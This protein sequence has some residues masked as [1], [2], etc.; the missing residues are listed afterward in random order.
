MD[1]QSDPKQEQEYL[2]NT[3]ALVERSLASIIT[4]RDAKVEM[5]KDLLS[6]YSSANPEYYNDIPIT[7]SL[8]QLY[9]KRIRGYMSAQSKPYFG[10][11]LFD[12]QGESCNFYIGKIGIMDLDDMNNADNMAGAASVSSE[13][14]ADTKALA[15]IDW[16]APV[17][18][19]YYS[20]SFGK[21]GYEAPGGYIEADIHL[22]TAFEIEGGKIT[23]IYDSD[24]MANDELLLKY[25]SSNKDTVLT[26]IVAT[27]QQEQNDIIRLSPEKTVIVQGVAGSGKTTVA[28]HR[29]SYLLY[30]YDPF[31]NADNVY[32]IASGKL[33]LNYMTSMLPDL[34]VPEIRQGTLFDFLSDYIREYDPKF[35]CVPIAD[36]TMPN[37][38]TVRNDIENINRYFLAYE[39]S[40][41]EKEGDLTLFGVEIVSKEFL[42]Q[43]IRINRGHGLLDRAQLLDKLVAE[44]LTKQKPAIIAYILSH[45]D[46]PA[47]V[48]LC[49]SVLQLQGAAILEEEVNKRFSR[50]VSKYKNQYFSKLKRLN[51]LKLYETLRPEGNAAPKTKAVPGAKAK[52]G[53]AMPFSIPQL[54][55]LALV[56]S[57]L[58]LNDSANEIRHIVID[59]AQ[60]FGLFTYCCLEQIFQKA[61]FTLVGDVM[62]VI[63]QSGLQSWDGVLDY[64]FHGDADFRTLT[65]S[66]RNTIEISAFA[67]SLVFAH[68]DTPLYI[69][70]VIRHGRQV[71]F[72]KPADVPAQVG[73]ILAE[74]RE[75]GYHICAV[76]CADASAAGRLH[77]AIGAD[78][79]LMLLDQS[80]DAL[81]RG[82]YILSLDD[83]KGLEFD[84]V[85]LP[86][87]DAYDLDGAGLKRAYVA[88]TRALH[89][90]HILSDNAFFEGVV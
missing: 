75:N 47:V 30:N 51:Y 62:Q 17:S 83:A 22:K 77:E 86:D 15:V 36:G 48:D 9:T 31:L 26:D 2:E 19:L 23:G 49:T 5:L 24:V 88:A 6:R 85:I 53:A 50:L 74:S 63:G 14:S 81:E 84:L 34:D 33:F 55:A 13:A 59:E 73:A 46:E 78:N 8:I 56:V 41:Y 39:K 87:F 44:R 27:I 71:C 82:S 68:G 16:R 40:F 32:V 3:L 37:V 20:T 35:K 52:P 64:A 45:Q 76:I 66:Y 12:S 80:L 69:E 7:E 70:P 60:D 89:E 57:H 61:N 90:L 29:V 38:S 21:S 28:I 1:Y 42:L 43:F 25:L 67:Q 72:Y 79:G 18:D 54:S 10:R 65:K 4:I 58:R 11:I